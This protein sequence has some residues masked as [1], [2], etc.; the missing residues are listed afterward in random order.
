[1]QQPEHVRI[2]LDGSPHLVWTGA[3]CVA[4]DWKSPEGAPRWRELLNRARS[5]PRKLQ[6]EVVRLPSCFRS[7]DLE[8]ADVDRLTGQFADRWPDRHQSLL[9]LGLRTSGSYLGP[10]HVAY[11]RRRGFHAASLI[12]FRPGH[13]LRHDE[14][15]RLASAAQQDRLAI[16]V[17]DP[18]TTGGAVAA[19]VSLLE[20]A[21]FPS[22]R[23]VLSLPL[24]GSAAELPERLRL[25][26]AVLVDRRDWAVE[27]RLE[28]EAVQASLC[29]ILPG[30]LLVESV[31]R[32]PLH[33]P[34][35]PREDSTGRGHVRALFAAHLRDRAGTAS[36]RLVYVKGTGLGYFGRHSVAV[37]E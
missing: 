10:L 5:L 20:G 15:Q 36:K 6:S 13:D 3:G 7:F 28:P 4:A 34:V 27:E 17:D 11:L 26:P 29:R 31:S 33:T 35:D 19:A 8:P 37:A 9:V 23:V 14:V 24:L 1:M 21:G 32:Q 12:T 16:V 22:S 30:G 25:V 2:G 18:P